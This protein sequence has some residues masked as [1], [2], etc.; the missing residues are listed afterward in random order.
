MAVIGACSSLQNCRIQRRI[1]RHAVPYKVSAVMLLKLRAIRKLG[2]LRRAHNDFR[3]AW[4]ARL[5]LLKDHQFYPADAATRSCYPC[6]L[7]SSHVL[8]TS[9]M[10]KL[11][12]SRKAA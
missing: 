12:S 10:P 4:T 6:R 9:S 8:Q 7:P 11:E 3:G 5:S 1:L 2:V